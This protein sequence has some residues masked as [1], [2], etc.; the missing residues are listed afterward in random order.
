MKATKPRYDRNKSPIH[1]FAAINK[2]MEAQVANQMVSK[3]DVDA[4]ELPVRA[5]IKCIE[6]H[7]GTESHYN[8]ICHMLNSSWI[9]ATKN[10]TGEEAKPYLLV[11]QDAMKRLV[12]H[13]KETGEFRLDPLGLVSVQNVVD[14]WHDQLLLCTVREFHEAS[15]EAD[16]CFWKHRE[17]A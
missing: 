16:E 10:Q 13:F 3:S 9:L 2:L 1:R 8:E 11:A 12:R 14:L 5:A 4:M 17:A 6:M 15:K 7:C